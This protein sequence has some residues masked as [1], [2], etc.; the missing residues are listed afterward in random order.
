MPERRDAFL[1]LVEAERVRQVSLPGSEYDIRN[2]PNDWV[3]I[4]SHY[5][6]EEVRRGGVIPDADAYAASLV[7]AAAV[8]AAAYEHIEIMQNRVALV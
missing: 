2:N 7:K 8:I 1:K 3:A 5:L 4:A 6:T